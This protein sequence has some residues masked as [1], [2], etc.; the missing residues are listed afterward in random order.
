MKM[1]NYYKKSCCEI[2]YSDNMNRYEIVLYV[3][4]TIEQAAKETLEAAC[5]VGA[6][7]V[8][9]YINGEEMHLFEA[10]I[11]KSGNPV[12]GMSAYVA[13]D[14]DVDRRRFVICGLPAKCRDRF[15]DMAEFDEWLEKCPFDIKVFELEK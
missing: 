3:D 7:A 14:K 5:R 9:P 15:N 13:V 10:D 11:Y 8:K 1:N 2:G 12:N 6:A 4:F